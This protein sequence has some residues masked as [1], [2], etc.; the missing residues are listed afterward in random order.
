MSGKNIL[1]ILLD[2]WHGYFKRKIG[3]TSY[4]TLRYARHSMLR[5]GKLGWPS[6]AYPGV[7]EVS[8]LER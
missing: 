2:V 3:Y 5:Y 7:S 4:A 1:I 6:P 8:K